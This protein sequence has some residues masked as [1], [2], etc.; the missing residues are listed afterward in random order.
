[1]DIA[2]CAALSDEVICELLREHFHIDGSGDF[3]APHAKPAAT[4][5]QSEND[6]KASGKQLSLEE[7]VSQTLPLLEMEREAEVAQV[8][9]PA[10][11]HYNS[12]C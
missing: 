12:I 11:S 8:L 2:A 1:M 10:M 3:R 9:N 5:L 6:R 4:K 7:F